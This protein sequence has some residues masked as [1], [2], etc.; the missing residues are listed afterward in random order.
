[1]D[2]TQ[3]IG[4]DA[5]WVKVDQLGSE[6]QGRIVFSKS[7]VSTRGKSLLESWVTT[8]QLDWQ[9]PLILSDLSQT[10]CAC[11]L[12]EWLVLMWFWSKS[13]KD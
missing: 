6:I 5:Q 7:N 13:D 2:K 3:Y 9:L 4:G 8:F 11:A 10:S 1:M 12:I